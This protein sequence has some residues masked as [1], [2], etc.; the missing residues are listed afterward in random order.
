MQLGYFHIEAKSLPLCHSTPHLTK[1]TDTL[2][3]LFLLNM[4]K[5]V[6]QWFWFWNCYA[7]FFLGHSVFFRD[8][9]V[10][11]KLA[12]FIG[13]YISNLLLYRK[14]NSDFESKGY[15]Q[16]DKADR[17]TK[18]P[19]DVFWEFFTQHICIHEKNGWCWWYYHRQFFVFS[20][21]FLGRECNFR[22]F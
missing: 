21:K 1:Q 5:F 7:Q 6:K 17:A 9:Q 18:R 11:W 14:I 13:K 15:K 10:A 16:A 12:I 3:P 20:A 8:T 19:K 2:W 22:R 4:R